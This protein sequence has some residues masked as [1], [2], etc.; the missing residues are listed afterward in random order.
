MLALTFTRTQPPARQDSVVGASVILLRRLGRTERRIA[1][2]VVVELARPDAP[3]R[4]ETATTQN[5]SPG[6]MRVVTEH[7]WR[8]GDLV[9]LGSP[10][11]GLPPQAR[12]VYCLR[13]DNKRFAI[14]L[15]FL[16]AVEGRTKP[17]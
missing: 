16:E 4:R 1:T 15:E 3:W 12:I 8:P 6:G 9:L 17:P 7:V 14:G 10:N 2:Q 13:L 11:I 5:V